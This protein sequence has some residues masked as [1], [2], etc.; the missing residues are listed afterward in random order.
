MIKPDI[1]NLHHQVVMYKVLEKFLRVMH[2]FMPFVTEEI[3]QRLPHDGE[4][5]MIQSWPHIQEQIIDKKIENK[6]GI[7]FEIITAVRNMR[8]ELE[9][10]LLNEIQ[11]TV[12]TADK[13][14][15]N[16]IETLSLQ[17]KK[18][19]RLGTLTLVE[20][21]RQIKSSITAVRKDIHITIPLEGVVDVEKEKKKIEERIQKTESEIKAKKKTLSHKEF[22]KKAPEEIIEKERARL[23]ELGD[24]LKRIKDIK[25]ELQ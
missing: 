21:Y 22:L 25:K 2:P 19:A 24:I 10:P 4:S 11:V 1:Q 18:L 12:S 8:Q 17:I 3:W 7:I 9:I 5:I 6:M 20:K 14:N 15:K 23:K 16:L 13:E